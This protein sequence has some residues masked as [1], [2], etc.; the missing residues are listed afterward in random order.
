MSANDYIA[1]IPPIRQLY[2]MSFGREEDR[3]TLRWALGI[4]LACLVHAIIMIALPQFDYTT[5]MMVWRIIN[6]LIVCACLFFW[7]R[8]EGRNVARPFVITLGIFGVVVVILS[9]VPIG[10]TEW[11]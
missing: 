4:W 11:G 6:F 9:L 8:S 10:V 3:K 2:L 5:A 1:D 7:K